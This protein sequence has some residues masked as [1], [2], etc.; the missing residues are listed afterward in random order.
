MSPK[1]V[2]KLISLDGHA[3]GIAGYYHWE[4]EVII[5]YIASR[6]AILREDIEEDAKKF[7]VCHESNYLEMVEIAAALRRH[8]SA[9]M[10]AKISLT[11][12]FFDLR[13]F[14]E[15]TKEELADY[16]IHQI[17]KCDLGSVFSS[18]Q[19]QHQIAYEISEL[20]FAVYF[21]QDGDACASANEEAARFRK[22]R[23]AEHEAQAR[24][25]RSAADA[26]A[27]TQTP[28]SPAKP[29]KRASN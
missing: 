7:G 13:D 28:T 12:T 3:H 20:A 29:R 26:G 23:D 6:F 5:D 21:Q 19:G 9:G 4:K 10:A 18:K 27:S 14:V 11:K 25:A 16:L 22:A 15:W 8:P 24:A 2:Q 17:V 1:T